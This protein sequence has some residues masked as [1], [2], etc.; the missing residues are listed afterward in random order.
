MNKDAKLRLDMKDNGKCITTSLSTSTW[1]HCFMGIEENWRSVYLAIKA[2]LDNSRSW[3]EIKITRKY[4]HIFKQF[5]CLQS[6]VQ[7]LIVRKYFL[8]WSGK[9]H[10][11]TSIVLIDTLADVIPKR[12][13]PLP[14]TYPE[15]PEPESISI[16]T[17]RPF[18]ETPRSMQASK[19]RIECFA[20]NCLKKVFV[21][22]LFAWNTT[23]YD[24]NCEQV[25]VN[26]LFG[27]QFW[28]TRRGL[29]DRQK[30]NFYFLF[31]SK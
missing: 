25:N 8:I 3:I 6:C 9:R 12:P 18:A 26:I 1:N 31:C 27:F 5:P 13:T 22:C 21:S 29:S 17:R 14:P 30:S 7:L 15:F 10:N 24:T 16:D 4:I 20:K 19:Q 2:Y 11:S 23:W 28:R